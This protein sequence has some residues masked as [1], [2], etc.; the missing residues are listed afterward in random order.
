MKNKKQ[1]WHPL[2]WKFVLEAWGA[3]T[4]PDPSTKEELGE[5]VE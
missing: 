2:A 1:R 5:L 4:S 3:G